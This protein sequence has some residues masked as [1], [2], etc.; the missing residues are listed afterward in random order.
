MEFFKELSEYKKPI[1][2]RPESKS[3]IT[4][5]RGRKLLEK[6]QKENRLEKKA[7]KIIADLRGKN[8]KIKTRNTL[9]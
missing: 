1:N 5:R 9:S 6:I 8:K 2:F 3:T 7:D 4:K